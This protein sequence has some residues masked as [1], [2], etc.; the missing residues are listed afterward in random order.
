MTNTK[1][2]PQ[3]VTFKNL[4]EGFGHDCGGVSGT[5][6]FGKTKVAEFYGDGW[7]GSI[8]DIEFF[9]KKLEQEAIDYQ[10]EHETV[11]YLQ[12]TEIFIDEAIRYTSMLNSIKADIKKEITR[13]KK[14]HNLKTK[15][16]IGS[17][18]YMD[19]TSYAFQMFNG[20]P[21]EI[22]TEKLESLKEKAIQNKNYADSEEVYFL[23]F[24]SPRKVMFEKLK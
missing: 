14:E 18:I 16:A 2:T 24:L 4:K 7:S 15:E 9:D 20:L 6:Y 23:K 10:K 17:L 11:E 1:M 21:T 19:K 3:N 22:S 5:M 12:T 8:D 13:F